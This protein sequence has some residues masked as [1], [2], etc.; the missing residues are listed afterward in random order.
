M[1][2]PFDLIDPVAHRSPSTRLF[3]KAMLVLT[4]S[5]A[6][7]AQAQAQQSACR[8]TQSVTV[9]GQKIESDQCMQNRGMDAAQF[10]AT[11][12]LGSEGMPSLGIPPIKV[13]FLPACPTQ[14][15]NVCEGFG[16]GKLT[17]YYYLK[18]DGPQRKQG[19]EATGGK[20][21]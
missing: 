9:A 3:F 17:S 16:Q 12:N 15:V 7:P 6:L 13:V 20:F 14:A 10:K 4:C 19:C 18:E 8:A 1:N 2:M 21:R 11:C 5:L